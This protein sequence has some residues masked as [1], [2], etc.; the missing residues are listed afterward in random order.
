MSSTKTSVSLLA[1]LGALM[2][3]TS[4]AIDIYLPA[5]PVMEEKLGGDAEL[6]IT[7]FLLDLLLRSYCGDQSVTVSGGKYLFSLA[8]FCLLLA[9]SVVLFRQT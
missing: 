5:M 2:A 6:A 3:M 9:P 4:I 7:G 1:I 8:W